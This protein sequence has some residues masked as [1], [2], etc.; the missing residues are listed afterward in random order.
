MFSLRVSSHISRRVTC[1]SRLWVHG[2]KEEGDRA[3]ALINAWISVDSRCTV[4]NST[5][6]TRSVTM[7]FFL[8]NEL[9]V[10]LV[11]HPKGLRHFIRHVI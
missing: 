7:D 4:A 8:W 5:V 6:F 11:Q 1:V 10:Q 3:A 9:K 2:C